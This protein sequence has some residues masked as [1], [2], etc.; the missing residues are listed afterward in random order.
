MAGVPSRPEQTTLQIV[1][2][3]V[4]KEVKALHNPDGSFMTDAN[5]Y[6]YEASDGKRVTL[7]FMAGNR[8]NDPPPAQPP[9]PSPACDGDVDSDGALAAFPAAAA[10]AEDVE[11]LWSARKTRFFIA[12]YSEMKDLVGKTRALR[13]LAEVLEKEHSVNPRL[14][15][16][17]GKTI[18]PSASPDTSI[19]EAPQDA[20]VPVECNTASKVRSSTT[21]K[22]KRQSRSQVTPL[23]EALEKMQASRAKQEEAA[24][25]QLE[26]RKKWEEAKAKRHDER[27]QRFDRLIDVLSNKDGL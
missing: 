14:L 13:E 8:E 15:L 25:K 3:G 4:Q 17:P 7:R 12:K 19:T 23:L 16:E 27:M 5:G 24:V 20:A 11:E 10:S 1:V 22:R 2:Q 21:P 26:E 18:L 6:V 9:T